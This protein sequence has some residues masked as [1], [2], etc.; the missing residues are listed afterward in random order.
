MQ[1]KQSI[2]LNGFLDVLTLWYTALKT[3]PSPYQSST[4]P[5]YTGAD[6]QWMRH[7]QGSEGVSVT[8]EQLL[9]TY[10]VRSQPK[11]LKMEMQYRQL[12]W[13][14]RHSVIFWAQKCKLIC[15]NMSIYRPRHVDITIRDLC[16]QFIGKT[17]WGLVVLYALAMSSWA[18]GIYKSV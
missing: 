13:R 4:P 11:W 3:N 17:V 15:T 2:R 18:N 8:V 12:T 16:I 1:Y 14:G 7:F 5:I 9:G 10:F 6:W